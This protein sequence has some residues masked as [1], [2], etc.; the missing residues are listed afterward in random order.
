[1]EFYKIWQTKGGMIGVNK[2]TLGELIGVNFMIFGFYLIL[3][4]LAVQ[5]LP[6]IL[7]FTYF[8]LL[9]D[10]SFTGQ[11]ENATEQRLWL[12]ILTIISVI[13][14]LIDFHHGWMS[15]NIFSN[16]VSKETFDSFA[17]FNITIGLINILLFFFGHEVYKQATSKFIRLLMFGVFILFG[18]KFI[19]PISRYVVSDVITQYNDTELTENRANQKI[20]DAEEDEY[21]SDENNAIRKQESIDK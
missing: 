17:I 5:L 19:K 11:P 21:N 10:D 8:L 9:L 18:F 4:A 15:F 1:M 6:V 16:V 14:F 12:N 7:L 20:E 3:L 13:Y 2:M